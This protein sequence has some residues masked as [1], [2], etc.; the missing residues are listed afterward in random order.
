MWYPLLVNGGSIAQ[1]LVVPPDQDTIG[2]DGNL[3][4]W[5]IFLHR[6]FQMVNSSKK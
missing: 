5:E 4:C 1:D 3:F 6:L 2:E